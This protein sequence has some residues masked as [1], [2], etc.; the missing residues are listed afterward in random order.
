MWSSAPSFVGLAAL[1]VGLCAQAP[2]EK[3]RRGKDA[4]KRVK[5]TLVVILAGEGTDK[6]DPRLKHIAQEIRQKCPNLKTFKLDSMTSRSLKPGEKSAFD[7][8]EGKKAL[9]VVK[10]GADKDDWVGLAVTPPDQGEIEYRTVCGKF[11]P[12]VTRCQT[13]GKD[14]LILAVRVQP[15][16][17]D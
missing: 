13:R 3:E 9:V 5:V 16:N 17:R 1:T 15:C 10:H 12:I 11:L 14:R 8:G 7:V 2:E 6:V 4:D